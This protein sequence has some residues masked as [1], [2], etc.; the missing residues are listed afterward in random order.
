MNIEGF[1][2][3]QWFC[4][5]M[6]KSPREKIQHGP[7]QR[8]GPGRRGSCSHRARGW[9]WSAGEELEQAGPGAIWRWA[10]RSLALQTK[11]AAVNGDAVLARAQACARGRVVLLLFE[12]EAEEEGAGGRLR[13][14]GT[15]RRRIWTMQSTTQLLN[16]AR[17]GE[18]APD[19]GDGRRWLP[20]VLAAGMRY[21]VARGRLASRRRG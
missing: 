10:A 9:I 6:I 7:K 15:A 8:S 1:S 17:T 11:R 12:A 21:L 20:C 5:K 13:D 3:K 14:S 2:V 4:G 16:P 18:G 19:P